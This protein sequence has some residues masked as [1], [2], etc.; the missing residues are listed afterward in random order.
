LP[1]QPETLAAQTAAES[2]AE[3]EVDGAAGTLPDDLPVDSAWEDIY[4]P[5]D[6]AT[7]YSRGE[8]EDWDLYER[9]AGTGESL[10]DHLYWQMRL[11][12]FDDRELVR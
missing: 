11:T 4:E 9:Y 2:S 10:R 7:S 1:V 8:E 3:T 5:F 12:P 6:G